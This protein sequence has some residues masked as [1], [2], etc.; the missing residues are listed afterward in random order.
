MTISRTPGL[1][2]SRS[3]PMRGEAAKRAAVRWMSRRCPSATAGK[4]PMR[5][6]PNRKQV[7]FKLGRPNDAKAIAWHIRRWRERSG[8]RCRP[9]AQVRRR[10]TGLPI[11]LLANLGEVVN[12]TVELLCDALLVQSGQKLRLRNDLVERLR[13]HTKRL[14]RQGR[15]VDGREFLRPYFTASTVGPAAEL[16]ASASSRRFR[17]GRRPLRLIPSCRR[18]KSARRCGIWLL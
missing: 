9:P 15:W 16:G 3:R 5:P 12:V 13:W 4:D 17:L 14:A 18:G 6:T 2:S 10:G 11:K 8:P 7:V 1:R